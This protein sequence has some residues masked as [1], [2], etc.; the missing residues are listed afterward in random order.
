MARTRK[1]P[2]VELHDDNKMETVY[3]FGEVTIPTSWDEITLQMM[4]DLWKVGHDKKQLLED[5]T[6]RAVKEKTD[7]PDATLDKYNVTDRDILRI[8]S[9][10]DETKIDLLPVELYERL[11]ANLAFVVE[12]Y[13]TSKPSKYIVHNGM[14]FLVNDM[15]TLKLKEFTDAETV[16]RSNQFDFPSLL[17]V[18]CRKKTGTKTDHATGLSWDVNE[19]YDEDFANKVFDARRDMFARMPVAKVMPLVSFFLLKGVASTK[20]SQRSL[21][22]LALQLRELVENIESS[23][24]SMDLP[25]LSK[26]RLMKTLKKYKKQINSTL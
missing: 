1:Q 12:P 7:K 17:A 10:I 8:F 26:R 13:E 4:C 16:I 18:L 2:K 24:E 23:V 6:K 19:V 21:T 3:D 14:T 25:K 15:E 5:D 20:V 11:M 9:T 22:T